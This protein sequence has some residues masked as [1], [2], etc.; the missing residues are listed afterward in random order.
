MASSCAN[1]CPNAPKR[2]AIGYAAAERLA[3][4]GGTIVLTDI[5]PEAKLKA[6]AEK[7]A[8]ATG[9]KTLGIRADVTKV[10]QVKGV[11]KTTVDT[12]GR[13]DCLFNN[14]GYQGAFKPLDQYPDEDFARV[15][16]INVE[17]VFYFLKYASLQMKE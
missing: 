9:A 14:A 8:S 16:Q 1:T 3:G 13:L 2:N 7:L 17:G 15:M 5:I 12:F 6:M 4:E 10:E 11:I